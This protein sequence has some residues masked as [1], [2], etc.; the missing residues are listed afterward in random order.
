MFKK[1]HR[2]QSRIDRRGK[3]IQGGTNGKEPTC[4][5]RRPKRHELDIWVGKIP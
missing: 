3:D 2:V 4:Q 1:G 5:C